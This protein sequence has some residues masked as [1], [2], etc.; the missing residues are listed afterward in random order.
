[1]AIIEIERVE[2]DSLSRQVWVFH[3]IAGY[4]SSPVFLR[5]EY[6]GKEERASKRH[7]WEKNPGTRY[8]SFD[9]RPYNS[10]IKAEDV[11]LPNDVA[12]EAISRF[13][14]SIIVCGPLGGK[15]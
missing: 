9:D 11:P 8:T 13:T 1:M 2:S 6:Y 12:G 10:G 14:Q 3:V 4:G 15:W 7:K 5:A